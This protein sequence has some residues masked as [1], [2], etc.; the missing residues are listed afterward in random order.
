VLISVV[1]TKVVEN[2]VPE[3]GDFFDS[4]LHCDYEDVPSAAQALESFRE[5]RSRLTDVQLRQPPGGS[6]WKNG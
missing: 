1:R 5:L 2:V 4:I 6:F 3:I